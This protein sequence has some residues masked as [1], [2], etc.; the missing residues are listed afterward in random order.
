MSRIIGAVKWF[1]YGL[2]IF[3]TMYISYSV[4]LGFLMIF[5]MQ[6]LIVFQVLWLTKKVKESYKLKIAAEPDKNYKYK[7]SMEPFTPEENSYVEEF[8]N[9][10]IVAVDKFLASRCRDKSVDFTKVPAPVKLL[11]V[12]KLTSVQTDTNNEEFSWPDTL[13]ETPSK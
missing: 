5:V 10:D 12:L 1:I 8:K 9:G 13:D 3:N 2:V 11:M 6:E 7:F 4:S